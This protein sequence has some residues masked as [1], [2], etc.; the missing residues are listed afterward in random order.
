MRGGKGSA[1][2]TPMNPEAMREEMPLHLS[3][4]RSVAQQPKKRLTIG[5]QNK[6]EQKACKELYKISNKK[7]KMYL[8]IANRARLSMP[9]DR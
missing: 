4:R 3:S 6:M 5:P 7:G 8:R 2:H 1:G 9:T